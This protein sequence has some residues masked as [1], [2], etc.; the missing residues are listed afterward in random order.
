LSLGTASDA[1][2]IGAGRR[3]TEQ[4]AQL[5]ALDG[6]LGQQR[7]DQTIE[8]GPLTLEELTRAFEGSAEQP[9]CLLLDCRDR[10][11]AGPALD[12]DPLPTMLAAS[13]TVTP[14]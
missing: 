4:G 13:R 11:L 10:R 12:R 7:G 14:T 2:G 5:V 8:G 6:L 1:R 9:A 3:T